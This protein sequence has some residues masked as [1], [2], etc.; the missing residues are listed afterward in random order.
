FGWLRRQRLA[1]TL[2]QT[3]PLEDLYDAL[4]HRTMTLARGHAETPS[5][6]EQAFTKSAIY[7]AAKLGEITDARG[8]SVGLLHWNEDHHV[9]ASHGLLRFPEPVLKR[10]RLCPKS[11][12]I[13]QKVH[14]TAVKD[15]VP[16][17]R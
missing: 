9:Q 2:L 17:G 13:R 5:A 6:L 15:D 8:D 4:D 7:C 12:E 3:N 16:A 11:D 14:G 10:I 1:G